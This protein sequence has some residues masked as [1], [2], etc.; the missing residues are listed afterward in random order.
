MAKDFSLRAE[1]GK[2]SVFRSEL[3]AQMEL[4]GEKCTVTDFIKR[5]SY[6]LK[7]CRRAATKALWGGE[8]G[9]RG[10]RGRE[11]ERE[12]ERGVRSVF[13]SK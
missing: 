9:G 13:T 2:A 5:N 10:V 4:M 3:P 8:R 11:K 7:G 1:V 12:R 6:H